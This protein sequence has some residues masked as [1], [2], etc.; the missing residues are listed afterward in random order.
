MRVYLY[1]DMELE[2]QRAVCVCGSTFKTSKHLNKTLH[3]H[4][5][6]DSH[7]ILMMG[8]SKEIHDEIV[9]YRGN[10]T[11]YKNQMQKVEEGS[12]R[13]NELKE[14]LERVQAK[15]QRLESK[16]LSADC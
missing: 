4:L 16:W 2:S 7:K 1:R 3:R 6:S 14:Y 10:I 8:G 13:W 12:G 11:G 9:L 15:L 5:A